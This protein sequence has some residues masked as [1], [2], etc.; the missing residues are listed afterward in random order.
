MLAA[1]V[2]LT[3]AASGH[4]PGAPPGAPHSWL[5]PDAWVLEHWL[6]YDETRL[7]RLVGTSREEVR[8]VLSDDHTPLSVLAERRGMSA[9][10][11]ARRLVEPWRGRVS[12]ARYGT[13][14]RR[15][16]ATFTHPHLARHMYFHLFHQ[17]SIHRASRQIFGVSPKELSRLRREGLNRL[18]IGTR[19]GRSRAEMTTVI[20]RVLRAN[21]D[22]AVRRRLMPRSQAR[23]FFADQRG[24]IDGFLAS[25]AGGQQVEFG[26]RP[27][28]S[29]LCR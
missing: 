6:P 7:Y 10:T 2:S 12:R 29:M 5:P 22:G 17:P 19:H 3:P 9:R 8:R 14:Y 4:D 13:L 28:A 26:A 1:L 21:L 23:R 20:V 27:H 18:E 24:A 15:T 11:L 16:K 25:R